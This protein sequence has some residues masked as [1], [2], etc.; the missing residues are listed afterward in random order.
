MKSVFTFILLCGIITTSL[1]YANGEDSY[2]DMSFP[3][4][5]T[6]P[7]DAHIHTHVCVTGEVQSVR[8]EHDGDIHVKLCQLNYCMILE[9][10]PEIPIAKPRK[11]MNIHACGIVRWDGWHK[12]Q[13]LHPLIKWEVR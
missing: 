2:F 10:I 12:W 13:E 5:V 11:G 3:D 1:A 9:I 6:A 4:L 8:K 7:P